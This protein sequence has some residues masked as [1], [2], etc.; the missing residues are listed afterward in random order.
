[1]VQFEKL[2]KDPYLEPP[3]DYEVGADPEEDKKYETA[4]SA[5]NALLEEIHQLEETAREG[6]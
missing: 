3:G 2:K 1:M 4:I 5:M 6:T